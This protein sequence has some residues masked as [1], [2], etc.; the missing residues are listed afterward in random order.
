MGINFK[1][2]AAAIFN[3][4]TFPGTGNLTF[5]AGNVNGRYIVV[6][7][8]GQVT[9]LDATTGVT[10][11]EGN[12]YTRLGTINPN[13]PNNSSFHT[14]W[15]APVTHGSGAPNVVSVAYVFTGAITRIEGFATEYENVN[16]AAAYTGIFNNGR[17]TNNAAITYS[18]TMPAGGYIVTISGRC[19]G[20]VFFSQITGTDRSGTNNN[21]QF[22]VCDQAAPSAGANTVSNGCSSP[23]G[24][25]MSSIGL[26][27]ALASRKP[28]IGV[29]I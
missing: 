21:S 18:L 12:I 27:P 16:L 11:T 23:T 9:S 19:A 2:G 3:L 26:N 14:Y 17:A 4:T 13:D 28:L 6:E 8:W 22:S 10:D 20:G 7:V 25:G 29:G 15:G 5:S 1:Q 24:W